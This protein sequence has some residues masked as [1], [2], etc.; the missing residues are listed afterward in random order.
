M[1]TLDQLV[2]LARDAEK[3]SPIDWGRLNI[4]EEHAYKMI[5]AS[6]HE[7]FVKE[8]V[9]QGDYYAMLA[10]VVNLTVENFVLNLKIKSGR[11]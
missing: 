9:T 8:Q 1:I 11:I 2:E 5:A 10:C 3:E 7:Q 4:S 6:V